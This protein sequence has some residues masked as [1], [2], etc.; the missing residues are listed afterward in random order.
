M[1][2]HAESDARKPA[3]A[4]LGLA[5]VHAGF[6]WFDY[7]EKAFPTADLNLAWLQ[8]DVELGSTRG[9]L[10]ARTSTR[11]H[12]RDAVSMDLDMLKTR[13]GTPHAAGQPGRGL[14][15]QAAAGSAALPFESKAGARPTASGGEGRRAP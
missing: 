8:Q 13:L 2:A 6:Q 4:D 9:A 10:C 11:M 15:L 1:L 7:L 14:P 12:H 3:N 5:A